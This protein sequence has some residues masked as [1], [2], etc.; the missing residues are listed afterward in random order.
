MKEQCRRI[1]NQ[2][3]ISS[4]P[5]PSRPIH[6]FIRPMVSSAWPYTG[7]TRQQDTHISFTLALL[8]PNIS[9]SFFFPRLST[10]ELLTVIE[11]NNHKEAVNTSPLF[12]TV[13]YIADTPSYVDVYPKGKKEITKKKENKKTGCSF[14][15]IS[16]FSHKEKLPSVIISIFDPVRAW[17]LFREANVTFII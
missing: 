1:R 2:F 9:S 3:Q 12:L 8:H 11:K 6:P 15:F 10:P 7:R 14:I 16:L 17:P 5:S 13:L 4:W